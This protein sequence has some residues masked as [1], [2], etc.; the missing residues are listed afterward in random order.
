LLNGHAY[1]L[2]GIDGFRFNQSC[3]VDGRQL[4]CGVSA[5]RALQTLLDPAAVTCTPK[6]N[7][8][9]GVMPATCMGA[10]GDVALTLVEQ[11][12]ALADRA[13]SSDYVA[14]E[15]AARRGKAGAW[16][17]T[18]LAPEAYRAQI[19][20]IEARYAEL[21]GDAARTEA[22]ATLA[23]GRLDFGGLTGITVA[24]AEA[25]DFREHEASFDEF[26]PGFI[27][28]AIKPPDV[29]DWSKVAAVL[30]ATRHKGVKTLE[31]S[32]VNT[33]W[34][35]LAARP[36]QTVDA[37]T[38]D[39][40]YAALKSNSAEW[41]AAGR[42]PVLFV[43]APSLPSWVR[44]WFAGRLPTGAEVSRRPDRSSPSYLGTIDGIDVY[45]GPGRQR[46][47][48]LVPA[49][50]LSGVTY[51][52]DAD[53]RILELQVEAQNQWVLRYAVTLQWRN[54]T[55]VWMAFPQMA[56]PTPDAD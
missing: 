17:G 9:A 27:D 5:V 43:M 37:R 10:D 45:V 8:T 34:D 6:G 12:W 53:G 41:I 55:P 44:D 49:D 13:E 14:A 50:I 16:A 46:A 47:A 54:D 2:F 51:R 19:A 20:A 28:A 25:G 15:A 11:G 39:E 32:V 52:K 29:F 30:D 26:S 56:A 22:E 35:E 1:R 38:G 23:D 24:S 4:A 36:S 18:F 7:S 3:F 33:I 31:A 21:A 42:Q 48:L 40:F